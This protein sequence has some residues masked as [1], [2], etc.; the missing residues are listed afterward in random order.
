MYF[1]LSILCSNYYHSVRDVQP[2]KS[3]V[4]VINHHIVDGE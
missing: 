1:L 3:Q 4:S 2:K